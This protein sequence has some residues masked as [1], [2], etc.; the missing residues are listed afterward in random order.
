MTIPVVPV[1]V[2]PI[3]RSFTLNGAAQNPLVLVYP[4]AA[5]AGQY[6]TQTGGKAGA[7]PDRTHL[8]FQAPLLYPVTYS[9][10]NASP[11]DPA[12]TLAAGC[13]ILQAG[14]T[15]GLNDWV[16]TTPV[17]FNGGAAANGQPMTLTEC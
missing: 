2:T 15:W 5:P 1:R 3:D 9:Y 14:Q 16:P 7:N 8:Q 13:Y 6:P 10:T 11:N 12:S 17:Y 4:V